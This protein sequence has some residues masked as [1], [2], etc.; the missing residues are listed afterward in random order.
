MKGTREPGAAPWSM[1]AVPEAGKELCTMEQQL[2]PAGTTQLV[3]SSHALPLPSLNEPGALQK[4]MSR[5]LD[6]CSGLF[7]STGRALMFTRKYRCF[8]LKNGSYIPRQHFHKNHTNCPF[9]ADF[10]C[11]FWAV[12]KCSTGRED[13]AKGLH[14]LLCF[15]LELC[16]SR[17]FPRRS[18]RAASAGT[19]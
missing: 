17:H 10:N 16:G 8:A 6:T 4:G 15:V 19:I 18:P 14:V 2:S 5:S 12:H 13:F 9:R 3:L 11:T 1:E 7:N